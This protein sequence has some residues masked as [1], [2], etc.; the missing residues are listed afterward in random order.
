MSAS[1]LNMPQT[2]TTK[3]EMEVKQKMENLLQNIYENELEVEEEE[4]LD[5]ENSFD[6]SET[7]LITDEEW[8]EAE[9]PTY[10]VKEMTCENDMIPIEY[11][12]RAVEFW[13]PDDAVRPKSF[14]TVKHKFRKLTSLRELRRWQEQVNRGGTRLEKLKEIS[15]YTLNKFEEA[16]QNGI[17]IHDTDVARWALKAQQEI[18]CPGFTAS[19]RWVHRF[20]IAHRIVSRKVTKF[21]TKRT[22]QSKDNLEAEGNRFIENVKYYITRYGV[23]NVYNSNQSGFQLELH[24][25]RSLAVQGTKKVERVVQSVSATTHSYT[26]QPTISGDGRLLSPLFIV[27][28]EAAGT[29]G[30]RVQE[31]M[32]RENNIFVLASK[33]GKLTSH[34]FEIWLREVYFP[35]VGPK[36]VLLLDSWTGHCPDVIARNRPENAE[37]IVFLTIPA[38]TTGQRQPLDVYGFRLWKNFV[39]H[40]SDVVMLLDLEVKLHSRDSILKL[41]SLTHFQFSSPRFRNLFKYAWYKSGYVEI[42]PDEFETPVDFCFKTHSKPTCDICGA[43]AVITCAWC[44]KSLC[45]KHF[46]HHHHLCYNYEP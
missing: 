40:F 9:Q 10:D 34:H 39:K 8:N 32:F 33:S 25:G 15:S 44:R 5:F 17:I 37:D 6:I 12:R 31:T 42:R 26:I 2:P 23:E 13:K 20:K 16:V 7:N 43:I 45:L 30:P 38:G 18:N 22:L 4:S 1:F 19:L 11:K 24:A 21:I 29:F 28:K 27:L 3:T 35:N 36:S 46:F 41:Q 14:E